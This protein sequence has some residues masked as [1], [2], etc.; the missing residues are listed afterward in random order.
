MVCESSGILRVTGMR[1]QIL[2]DSPSFSPRSTSIPKFWSAQMMLPRS[3]S[4]MGSGSPLGNSIR[5]TDVDRGMSGYRHGGRRG[6]HNKPSLGVKAITPT[7][8]R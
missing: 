6:V 1:S 7:S 3:L 4:R 5:F 2:T 8:W